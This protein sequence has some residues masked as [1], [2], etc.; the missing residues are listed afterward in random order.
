MFYHSSDSLILLFQYYYGRRSLRVIHQFTK[1]MLLLQ[2]VVHLAEVAGKL[3]IVNVLASSHSAGQKVNK[4]Q[5]MSQL[6]TISV[7]GGYAEQLCW[8]DV[9]AQSRR[10]SK[11]CL[12]VKQLGKLSERLFI[13]TE[14]LLAYTNHRLLFLLLWSIMKRIIQ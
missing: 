10:E 14:S 13:V 11:S 1:H 6:M 4:L 12:I 5:N 7:K 3:A 8:R 2:I 9:G